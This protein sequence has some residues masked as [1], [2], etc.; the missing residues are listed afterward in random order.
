MKL[1]GRRESSNVEDRR[2]GGTVKTAGGITL[3]GLVMGALVY[4]FTGDLGQ[5]ISTGLS[6]G[7]QT[8]VQSGPYQ[9]TAQEK[10]LS[11]FCKQILASTE[12]VWSAEFKRLGKTYTPPTLVFYKGTTKT[13]C[14]QGQ[15]TS[16]PFYCSGDQKIYLDLEFLATMKQNLGASGDFANAYVIAHEVGHHVQEQLGYLGAAHNQ[17]A[18][19]N[20]VDANKMSV[21]IE[22]QADYIAGVWGNRENATHFSLDAGDMAEALDAAKK[23]GDDYLQKKAGY[24]QVQ[25]DAFTHGTS[26]QRV[27]WLNKG[28]QSGDITKGDTYSIPYNSL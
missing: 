13:A 15:A 7:E 16:G 20:E 26:D 21:R 25:A 9:E 11:T 23:I 12:D 3:G 2:A 19:M 5:A 6:S 27:R 8:V 18:R 14:G 1:S 4:F 24:R 17:M 22:L 10:E 28:L